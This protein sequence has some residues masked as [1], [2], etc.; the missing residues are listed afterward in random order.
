[1]T[2]NELSITNHEVYGLSNSFQ[3]IKNLKDPANWLDKYIFTYNLRTRLCVDQLFGRITGETM[4]HHLIDPINF[5]FK[6]H[7]ADLFQRTFGQVRLNQQPFPEILTICYFR[8][9]WRWQTCPTTPKKNFMIKLQ[10]PWIS[11]SMQKQ[12][13]Y[14]K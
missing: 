10:L 2:W 3:H 13:F 7:I 1:M 9:L 5:F 8:A 11:Y 14:L 12:T 6:I 4:V